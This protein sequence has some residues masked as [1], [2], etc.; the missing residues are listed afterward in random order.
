MKAVK[1]SG[2]TA[3]K[4]QD[5]R[6]GFESLSI[7]YT[8]ILTSKKGTY[9]VTLNP[10][11][12]ELFLDYSRTFKQKEADRTEIANHPASQDLMRNFQH[13][14]TEIFVEYFEIVGNTYTA[15]VIRGP[16]DT[17]DEVAKY[18]I[19]TLFDIKSVKVYHLDSELKSSFCDAACLVCL[20]T[21]KIENPH[22][23]TE[24]SRYFEVDYSSGNGAL[25][26][27]GEAK[28]VI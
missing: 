6:I 2:T 20:L 15:T 12:Y 7:L 27:A 10:K 5:R 1:G 13:S 11:L 28:V 25:R 16:D 23:P 3:L 19:D 26:V 14:Y 9:M 8:I 21:C 18:M 22:P 4:P 17:S 24:I